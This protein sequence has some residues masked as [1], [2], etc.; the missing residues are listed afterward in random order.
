MLGYGLV[1][2]WWGK[3]GGRRKK[4]LKEEIKEKLPGGHKDEHEQG[5][6]ERGCGHTAATTG[7]AGRGTGY[8][9]GHAGHELDI[10]HQ[11]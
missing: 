2:G 7:G 1:G 8:V 5:T 10:G 11:N 4:G 6:Y 3:E 9:I